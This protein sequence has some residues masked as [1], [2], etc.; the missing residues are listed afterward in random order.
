MNKNIKTVPMADFSLS[1]RWTDPQY[2]V[3]SPGI[4]EQI[5]PLT[6]ASAAMILNK[7]EKDCQQNINGVRIEA[8]EATAENLLKLKIKDI[9]EI[10]ISWDADTAVITR[11]SV[12]CNFWNSF[13]YPSSDDV[14][15][16]SPSHDWV[17]CYSHDEYFTY[18]E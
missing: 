16:W 8:N 12:F 13:C 17:L 15:I 2:D 14:I 6:S 5:I 9:T 1:W 11:W 7:T 18:K 10:Y 4:L 3:L